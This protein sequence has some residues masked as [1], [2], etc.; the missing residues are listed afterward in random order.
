VNH[1]QKESSIVD[2]LSHGPYTSSYVTHEGHVGFEAFTAEINEITIIWRM[3]PF[4]LVNQYAV[5][6]LRSITPQMAAVL[7]L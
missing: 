1:F 2:L 6:E 4:R 3:S 7:T 5:I